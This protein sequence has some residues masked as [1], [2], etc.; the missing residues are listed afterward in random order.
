[1]PQQLP[2]SFT[3]RYSKSKLHKHILSLEP[4]EV[5]PIPKMNYYPLYSQ[6]TSRVTSFSQNEMNI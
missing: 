6:S 5:V 2:V 3:S 4:Y 1:M